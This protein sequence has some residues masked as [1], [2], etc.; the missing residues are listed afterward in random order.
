MRRLAVLLLIALLGLA[1][2]GS[3]DKTENASDS[4]AVTTTE[5]EA[6]GGGD[7]KDFCG[8]E[9]KY[10]GLED[11]FRPGA[12]AASVRASLETAQDALDDGVRLAPSEIK[13]DMKIIADAFGPFI[14]AM[15][16]A[17]FDFTKVNPE[18]PAF[19]NVQKPEV[20]AA[21]ARID[22]WVDANCKS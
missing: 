21:S 10:T 3:D 13:A 14:E 5:A 8:L 15:A 18:D 17:N 6:S 20:Q 22:A 4:D 19:A 7:A 2:C 12:D 16:K 11:S 1:A 9:S